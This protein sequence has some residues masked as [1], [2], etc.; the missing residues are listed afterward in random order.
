MILDALDATRL[1]TIPNAL[2]AWMARLPHLATVL[3]LST[4]MLPLYSVK[5]ILP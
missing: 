1:K 2:A 4:S 3:N 5:V